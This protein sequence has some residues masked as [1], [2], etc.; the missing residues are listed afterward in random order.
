MYTTDEA[1]GAA[2]RNTEQRIAA[3]A[4]VA[5]QP[6]VDHDNT[7]MD[8]TNTAMHTETPLAQASTLQASTTDAKKDKAPLA[9]PTT[10][11]A[12]TKGRPT[13]TT[14]HHNEQ[15]SPEKNAA[16]NDTGAMML[17]PR[18]A[19]EAPSAES[20]PAAPVNPA[21]FSGFVIICG[22]VGVDF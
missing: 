6:P 10:F 9:Q 5:I 8:Q 19:A 1:A 4:H 21:T 13:S 7:D 17:C 3:L 18:S 20:G 11:Q 12:L 16:L 15:A 22:G 2:L 14:N